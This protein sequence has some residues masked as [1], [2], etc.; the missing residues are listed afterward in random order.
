MVAAGVTKVAT[1][2]TTTMET[3]TTVDT[4]IMTTVTMITTV[5]MVTRVG[6]TTTRDIT[7]AILAMDLAV[8]VVDMEEK[9]TVMMVR[10]LY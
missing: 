1:I 6:A 3:M 10:N 7:K 8:M 5:T 4:A 9:T 2:T